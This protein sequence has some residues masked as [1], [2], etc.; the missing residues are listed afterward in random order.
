MPGNVN[1]SENHSAQ[2]GIAFLKT[3]SLQMELGTTPFGSQIFPLQTLWRPTRAAVRSDGLWGSLW[4]RRG[5]TAPRS[6]RCIIQRRRVFQM[7]GLEIG[8]AV[9]YGTKT[10]FIVVNNGMYI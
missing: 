1:Y 9:Q 8:T 4:R 5:N 6:R 7:N 2:L 10:I 3:L